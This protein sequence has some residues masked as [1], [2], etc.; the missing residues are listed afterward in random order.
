M[1]KILLVEPAY[2]TKFAPLGLMRISSYHKSE[3]DVVSFIKGEQKLDFTPDKIYITSL[4]TY[5][6]K[7]TLKSVRFYKKQF[8]KAEIII[9]GVL[10][11]LM[12]DL[13]RKEGI[14]VHI[15]LLKEVETY[16][17]DYDLIEDIDY[18][19]TFTSR[20]CK[21]KCGFCVPQSANV[22]LEQGFEKINDLDCE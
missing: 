14:K 10:A 12:P 21:N 7:E 3:G 8:P 22:L 2:K 6:Y 9:G 17:P 19:L 5:R 20:G 15:G 18:S 11:T 1:K 4:F 13:F 16:P